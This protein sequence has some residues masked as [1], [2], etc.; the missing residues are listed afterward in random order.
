M[1]VFIDTSAFYAILSR[2]DSAHH[3]AAT[4]W[5]TIVTGTSFSPVT[6]NYVAVETIALLHNRLGVGAVEA[7]TCNIIPIINMRWVDEAIH[8]AGVAAIL[9]GGNNGPS[10]VDT[11]SFAMMKAYGITRALAYDRHFFAQGFTI[12]Q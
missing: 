11:T 10:L 12:H 2:S 3:A 4:R 8:N 9:A 1:M 6:S 5:K 7:F